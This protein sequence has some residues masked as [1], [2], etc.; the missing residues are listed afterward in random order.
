V[1]KVFDADVPQGTYRK[2][3]FEIHKVE[4]SDVNTDARFAGLKN[5]SVVIDGTVDGKAFSFVSAL[6]EEQERDGTFSVGSG[7]QNLTL[8]LDATKWFVASGGGRLDPSDPGV[9]KSKIE[10]NIKGSIDAY[11]DDDQNG[12]RD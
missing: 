12:K 1:S 4:D 6:N 8:N 7:A 9:D 11:D 2:V 5:T 10:Q 3:K